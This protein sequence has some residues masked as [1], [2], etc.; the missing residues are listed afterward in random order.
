MKVSV[1]V[2]DWIG[3]LLVDIGSQSHFSVKAGD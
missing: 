2:K 1:E 3:I